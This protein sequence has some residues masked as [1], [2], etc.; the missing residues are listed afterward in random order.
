MATRERF[1]ER[2]GFKAAEPDI[3][4][5]DDAPEE[6]R[7]IVVE[8]AYEFHLQPSALRTLVCRVLRKR[9]DHNNWSERPNIDYEVRR[10]IDEAE[11][12][13]VYDII[14][15][16]HHLLEKRASVDFTEDDP[17]DAQRYSSEMNKYFRGAGIG[18]QLVKGE[19]QFR[20]DDA[21]EN[22]VQVANRELL[23]KKR[24][25]S[26]SEL[27]QARNDLSR[28]PAPDVTGAV[29]HALAALEC[30]SRDVTGDEQATLG[31][32][33]KKNRTFLPPPLDS[34]VDKLWGFASERGRHLREGREP[35]LSEAQLIVGVVAVLCTYISSENSTKM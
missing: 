22:S 15:E 8:V 6:L 20:G 28:R 18:W 11:W 14:E 32:L 33:L 30:L 1:S 29:Q 5:R 25:T 17:K 2:H 21:F 24:K 34:A 35:T 19:L 4:V 7:G 9:P 12:Y 3:T 16:I 23:K 26:A 31:Q 27:Q 13:Q 10:M